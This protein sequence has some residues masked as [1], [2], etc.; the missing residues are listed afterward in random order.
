M[1]PRLMKDEIKA[2]AGKLHSPRSFGLRSTKRKGAASSTK[3]VSE[4]TTLNASTITEQ[5]TK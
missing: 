3:G 4:N 2:I 1:N 5:L